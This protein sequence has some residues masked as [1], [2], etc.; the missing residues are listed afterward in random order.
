MA[1]RLNRRR[2]QYS[3]LSI[4]VAILVITFSKPLIPYNLPLHEIIEFAGYFLVAVC[5]LGRVY[6]SAFL[7]GFKNTR[8]ITHGPFSVVRNPLYLFSLIGI[9]GLALNGGHVL[10]AVFLVGVFATM[11]WQLIRREERFL[12]A[13]FGDDYR[14]YMA[15][16]PRL[17]PKLSLYRCP[18]E[19]TFRPRF[20]ANACL[21]AIWWFAALP[22]FELIEYLQGLGIIPAVDGF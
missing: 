16:T 21:D 14:D 22:L 9:V 20:I 11:Y 5:A 10:V 4:A 18:E 12:L 1:T 8:L 13:E 15:R 3:W 6:T 19:V 17:L 2:I 7:G